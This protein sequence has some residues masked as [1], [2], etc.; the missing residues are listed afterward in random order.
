MHAIWHQ[1]TSARNAILSPREALNWMI[2]PVAP[3]YSINLRSIQFL[4]EVQTKKYLLRHPQNPL[5][6]DLEHVR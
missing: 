3:A 4:D 1:S 2:R 5:I 6:A